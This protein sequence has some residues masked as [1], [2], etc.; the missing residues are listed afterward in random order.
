MIKID[1]EKQ[2]LENGESII[3]VTLNGGAEVEE[4]FAVITSLICSIQEEYDTSFRHILKTIKKLYKNK[5]KV[6][7]NGKCSE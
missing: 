4:I 7:R 1:T 3:N 2:E 5:E 6:E